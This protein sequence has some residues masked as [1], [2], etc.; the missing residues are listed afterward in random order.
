MGSSSIIAASLP[1]HLSAFLNF[2]PDL[3]NG[4]KFA[5][6]PDPAFFRKSLRPFWSKPPLNVPKTYLFGEATI[7]AGKPNPRLR[8]R[9][10]SS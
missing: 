2:I 5:T 3:G 7:I 1:S 4:S 9:S 10:R 6:L 8:A